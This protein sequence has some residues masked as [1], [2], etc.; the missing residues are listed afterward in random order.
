MFFL[1][2]R[3]HSPASSVAP[4]ASCRSCLGWTLLCR[5]LCSPFSCF[6]RLGRCGIQYASGPLPLR[7]FRLVWLRPRKPGEKKVAGWPPGTCEM[8]QRR[9][10]IGL[11]SADCVVCFLCSNNSTRSLSFLLSLC[12]LFT[13]CGLASLPC[14]HTFHTYALFLLVVVWF[15]LRMHVYNLWSPSSCPHFS[16]SLILSQ[17]SSS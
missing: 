15:D 13:S 12:A 11:S 9:H 3:A 2:L 7:A 8:K 5:L 4:F 17:A 14:T 6:H 1:A 10:Q 16:L